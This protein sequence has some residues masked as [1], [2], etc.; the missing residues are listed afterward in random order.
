MVKATFCYLGTL[1]ISLGIVLVAE[2]KPDIHVVG[3]WKVCN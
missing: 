3:S 2:G 1:G